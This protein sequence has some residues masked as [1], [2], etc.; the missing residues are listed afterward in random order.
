MGFAGGKT[1]YSVETEHLARLTSDQAVD[2]FAELLWAEATAVGISKTLI[3]VPSN[4]NARDGGVDAVAADLP[5]GTT[6][7]LFWDGNVRYQV[8][9]GDFSLSSATHVRDILFKDSAQSKRNMKPEHL[10]DRVRSCLE[11]DE[12]LAVVLFGWDDPEREDE[13]LRTAFTDE[14]KKV[15]AAYEN[16]KLRFL[17]ANQLVSLFQRFPSLA[18]RLTGRSTARFQS[19]ESWS[20][21]A[22]MSMEVHFGAEQNKLVD[23]LRQELRVSGR[24]AHVH[25]FGEPGVGKTRLVLEAVSEEDLA[26]LTIYTNS[27]TQFLEGELL[28]EVL[29]SDNDFG[30]LLVIDECD[31]D[32]RGRIWS[33]LRDRGDRIRLVTIFSEEYATSG[34]TRELGLPL[35]EAVQ[36]RKILESYGVLEENSERWAE[37]C[38]GSPRFAHMIGRN[39][40]E[41]NEDVLANPDTV[42]DI[43]SRYIA[44]ADN[45][46]SD[47]VKQRQRVLGYLSLFKR[48]GFG[49]LV[50]DEAKFIAAEIEKADH[51]ITWPIF[52][53][54]VHELRRRKI[55]QGEDTLYITPKALH[56]KLWNEWW[57][58]RAG[59]A[60]P[61]FVE[62]LPEKLR[63]WFVDMFRY[64]RDVGASGELIKKLLGPG[65]PCENVEFL[66]SSLG[67]GFFLA[68]TDANADEALACLERT[69]GSLGHEQLEKLD[70]GRRSVIYALERMVVWRDLFARGARILLALAEA[71]NEDWANNATGVFT[72]LFSAGPGR[73]APTEAPPLE[74]L[75]VL[76]EAL[77]AASPKRRSIVLKGF[78]AALETDHFSRV[79]GAEYQGMRREPKL[80]SPKTY[81]E[82]HDGYKAAWKSLRKAVPDLPHDDS[83]E[84]ARVLI[85]NAR[86]ISRIPDFA[87]TV[88]E[89]VRALVDEY[90]ETREQALNAALDMLRY[91]TD[92]SP[93]E[94]L[95]QWATLR[96]ELFGAGFAAELRRFVQMSLFED[97]YDEDGA[98]SEIVE[99]GIATLAERAINDN[100][101]LEPELSW[102][103]TDEANN[104]YQFGF[105]IGKR[106]ERR[107]LLELLLA[108]QRAAGAESSPFFLAGYLGAVAR[109]SLDEW[110]ERMDGLAADAE[111][112]WAVP[113]LTWRS[114]ATDRSVRRIIE[115]AQSGHVDEAQ[116]RYL[117]FGGVARNIS[118]DALHE[119]I[120][121]LLSKE[122]SLL[123][124]VS[125]Q[126]MDYYYGRR[127][128]KKELPEQ[129][130]L[131]VLLHGS[132]FRR[133]DE[134][135]R[136]QMDEFHWAEVATRYLK[137]FPDHGME[138]ASVLMDAL[139]EDRSLAGLSRGR[140]RS[141]LRDII[142]ENPTESWQLISERLGPPLDKRSYS[143]GM[144]LRGADMFGGGGEEAAITPLP[145]EAIWSWVDG[146]VDER[147]W[148]LASI[149]PKTLFRSDKRPC[150]AREVLV[151]YGAREDVRNN[152]R[153]NFSTEGWSG[154]TSDYL[155]GKVASLKKFAETESD[156]N[157]LLWVNEYVAFLEQ[158]RTHALVRE[159]RDEF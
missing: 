126:L 116:F 134:R 75:P 52:Q 90:P 138:I 70:A 67:S 73:T 137:Q 83:V 63:V 92:S 108:R 44:G 136:D 102:L 72:G 50:Q 77:R 32:S 8:K 150:L 42:A 99:K 4:I 101:L 148:Y 3:N 30:V 37:L 34:N 105:E 74:R 93:P 131:R 49:P 15:D 20:Q 115:L 39:L 27:P 87:S 107:S 155:A 124:S 142:R 94:A 84:A 145:L 129:L 17:Q 144:F 88:I 140:V 26:P 31:L 18:L 38:S 132:F 40:R 25:V 123:A 159:E 79:A 135:Y 158:D 61:E 11:K 12:T 100:E 45:R 110:E 69:L 71:E 59:F 56:I 58:V 127:G 122:K 9:T 51:S 68:L 10:R 156:A 89:T 57:E 113:E 5:E 117:S 151:R 64:A 103:V 21:D 104:G 24:A 147:A 141:L 109:D 154:P 146:N 2:F 152:L 143:L 85:S 157:V 106:D 35:L 28:N 33:R 62:Q 91:R 133:P 95:E 149:V 86:G 53:E 121:F 153:A 114:G 23:L 19:H 128:V 54:I 41:G 22:E 81:G 125:I 1:V 80:W 60:V 6:G 118:E 130:A 66:N 78:D 65:G 48:F 96:D 98:P 14:L 43:V 139:G 120:N 55:L 111:L 47:A 46:D 119:L 7:N 36:V 97:R 13:K 76:E 112:R 29:R 16:A 82:W